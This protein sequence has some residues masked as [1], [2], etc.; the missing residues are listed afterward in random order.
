MQD[1]KSPVNV[2]SNKGSV[3]ISAEESQSLKTPGAKCLPES[4]RQRQS[5]TPTVLSGCGNG[6]P[7]QWLTGMQV[8]PDCRWTLLNWSQQVRELLA[9]PCFSTVE[10][11]RGNSGKGSEGNTNKQYSRWRNQTPIVL[12]SSF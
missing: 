11:S 9:D 7:S 8:E 6:H 5:V 12:M 2:G 10:G 3:E 1:P 4:R